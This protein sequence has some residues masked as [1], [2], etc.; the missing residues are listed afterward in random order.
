[1]LDGRVTKKQEEEKDRVPLK[2]ASDVTSKVFPG[3]TFSF[4]GGPSTLQGSLRA[5]G[6]K[7][8]R[9]LQGPSDCKILTVSKVWIE[10]GMKPGDCDQKRLGV[11]PSVELLETSEV[12][13]PG[14]LHQGSQSQ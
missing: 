5:S 12:G 4:W 1:M 9:A 13:S 3:S 6:G 14:A 2:E 8:S 11:P 10:H 7:K